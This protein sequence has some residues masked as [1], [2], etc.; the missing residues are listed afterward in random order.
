MATHAGSF[1]RGG[2]WARALLG[3]GTR[4]PR[5]QLLSRPAGRRRP[6]PSPPLLDPLAPVPDDAGGRGLCWGAVGIGARGGVGGVVR[7]ALAGRGDGPVGLA[8]LL[9]QQPVV[10]GRLEQTAL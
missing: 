10:F 4:P 6:W 9:G 7:A 8:G 2:G 1:L 5:E 3:G